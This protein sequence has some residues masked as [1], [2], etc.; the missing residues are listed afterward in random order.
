MAYIKT[1]IHTRGRASYYRTMHRSSS[2]ALPSLHALRIDTDTGSDV[3]ALKCQLATIGKGLSTL[4]SEMDLLVKAIVRYGEASEYRMARQDM[5]GKADE[6]DIDSKCYYEVQ[7]ETQ[8][9]GE[10]AKF[11]VLQ[12]PY[13]ERSEDNTSWVGTR[14]F[15]LDSDDRL[16]Q[17][18]ESA[19][20]ATAKRSAHDLRYKACA[21]FSVKKA[22]ER[23]NTRCRIP[24]MET[25]TPLDRVLEVDSIGYYCSDACR[26]YR[27]NELK[28]VF[29]RTMLSI[30]SKL[31]KHFGCSYMCLQDAAHFKVDCKAIYLTAW[32]LYQGREPYYADFGFQYAAELKTAFE[33][34]KEDIGV[35]SCKKRRVAPPP[36]S[37][38][39]N[40]L[41]YTKD[42]IGSGVLRK[43]RIWGVYVTD[44]WL[45]TDEV[46]TENVPEPGS[47]KY[48]SPRLWVKRDDASRS[49]CTLYTLEQLSQ[50]RDDTAKE[51][52]R[53]HR[54]FEEARGK[55]QS[56]VGGME[57][58]PPQAAPGCSY[59]VPVPDEYTQ[60]ERDFF[61]LTEDEQ[62]DCDA[63]DAGSGKESSSSDES[64]SVPSDN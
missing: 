6:S 25:V 44:A 48:V 51:L 2:D 24:S 34:G 33:L 26:E 20:R 42:A 14:F 37:V 28:G 38:R 21:E 35:R 36:E 50:R 58:E 54:E 29:A 9:K 4:H 46:V 10:L 15:V 53:L 11:V 49:S 31:A 63:L 13:T 40:F 8:N 30:A 3:L 27:D 23:Y 41:N 59:E 12:L 52:Q 16:L 18:A 60:L 1:H 62:D 22:K 17:T 57:C 45:R 56:L 47:M 61:G 7:C 39:I 43:G 19:A 64:E 5:A 32:R 55:L